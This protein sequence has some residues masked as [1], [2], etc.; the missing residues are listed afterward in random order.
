MAQGDPHPR[1]RQ[2]IREHS[3][4]ARRG[5]G[6]ATCRRS[7]ATCSNA[8]QR[9]WRHGQTLETPRQRYETANAAALAT[10]ESVG[11]GAL[12]LGARFW[13]EGFR[14][15]RPAGSAGRPSGRAR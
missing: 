9:A 13:S 14:E 5:E 10:L 4:D 6:C 3:T 2:A 7:S 11:G 15:R 8:W 12:H 1:H